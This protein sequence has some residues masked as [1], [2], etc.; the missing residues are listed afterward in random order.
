LRIKTG[1]Q[2]YAKKRTDAKADAAHRH[3]HA[4]DAMSAVRGLQERKNPQAQVDHKPRFICT[5]IRKFSY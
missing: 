2:D 1:A 5:Y 4:A 3:G